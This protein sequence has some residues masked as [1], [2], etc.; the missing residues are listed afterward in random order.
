MLKEGKNSLQNV[1]LYGRIMAILEEDPENTQREQTCTICIYVGF[2]WKQIGNQNVVFEIKLQ[3][4]WA[5][6]I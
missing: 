4:N 5:N 2:M 1:L 3:L 6:M